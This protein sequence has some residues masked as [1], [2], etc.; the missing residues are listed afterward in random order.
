MQDIPLSTLT[1]QR[2]LRESYKDKNVRVAKREFSDFVVDGK[3]LFD[4]IG[5]DYMSCFVRGY[6]KQNVLARDYLL[7][8]D[9]T[10]P[11]SL[12]VCPE[13]ADIGCGAIQTR[14][15]RRNDD[16]VW[17]RL[18]WDNAMSDPIHEEIR[19]GF[20]KKQLG[21]FRFRPDT[22]EAAIVKASRI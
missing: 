14:V 10:K 22:Y 8:A 18:A 19:A 4:M 1:V 9:P 12:Y 15:V 7:H 13:C 11:I 6:G 16:V 5:G 3:S 17:E 2:R 20:A 21:P